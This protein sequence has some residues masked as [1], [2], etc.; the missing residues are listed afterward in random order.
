VPLL[1]AML[2][3][4]RL[5]GVSV[6]L[7]LMA[8]VLFIALPLW[9]RRRWPE[10]SA[11]EPRWL[12]LRKIDYLLTIPL[13]LLLIAWSCFV[14][15]ALVRLGWTFPKDMMPFGNASSLTA[16]VSPLRSFFTAVTF[17]TSSPRS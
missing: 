11:F 14:G 8:A 13:I 1:A 17:K 10:A 7:G 15:W 9:V 2:V 4:A 16:L 5:P 12:P 3:K 6:A